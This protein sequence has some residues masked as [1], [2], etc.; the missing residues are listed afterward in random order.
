MPAKK[1]PESEKAAPLSATVPKRLQDRVREEM[2]ARG[3]SSF[4]ALV[5]E[6]IQF[7]VDVALDGK[8]PPER[9]ASGPDKSLEDELARF[10]GFSSSPFV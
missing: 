1:K 9:Y 4:S 7:W 3:E 8:E 6:A 10:K 2:L 5:T